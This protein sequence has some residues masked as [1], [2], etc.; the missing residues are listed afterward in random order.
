M[1]INTDVQKRIEAFRQDINKHNPEKY[2]TL[3][4]GS[5][6]DRNS[7]YVAVVLAYNDAKRTL[8]GIGKSEEKK[9]KKDTA[10]SCIVEKL[11]EYF[12]NPVSDFEKVHDDLCSIWCNMFDGSDLDKYG[13]AQK[14]INMTF[15]Y[16]FCCK[17][18]QKDYLDYFENCHM[19]LDSYTLAWYKRKDNQ[20]KK[21]YTWSKLGEKDYKK[22]QKNIREYLAN[23]N[24]F[25]ISIPDLGSFPSKG[26]PKQP[27]L[28]EF[29]IWEG[30]K[31]FE[32]YKT[33]VKGIK[34]YKNSPT[35]DSWLIGDSFSD[36]VKN[37]VN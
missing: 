22:I 28:A 16:L 9:N 26:L 1:E 4:S 29:I 34:A 37:S 20:D 2:V 15:K 25:T 21:D 35:K 36:F 13:K 11:Y 10:I 33:L 5:V 30:E 23:D 12:S 7:I 14:I 8:S 6:I 17:D 18:A 24:S 3:N 19:T 32:S 31:I 27:F